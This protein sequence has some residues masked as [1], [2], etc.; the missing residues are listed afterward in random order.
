MKRIFLIIVGLAFLFIS[1]EDD[2]NLA[3]VSEQS[4]ADFY[5][6]TQDF[7]QAINGMYHALASYPTNQFYLSE[8][9][10]D[11]VWSPGGGVRF[12][13]PVNNFERTLA[14][15]S[16]IGDTW[17]SSYRAIF[18]ANI[19]LDKINEEKVP[20][21]SIR[22]RM[23]GEAEFIRALH[24]LDLV[25]FFGRIPIYDKVYSPTE[26]LE[27]GRSS[28]TDVYSLI[29]QDLKDAINKLPANY[30]SSQTGKATS[31][32]AK[33]L[34]AKVYL[35]ESGPDYGI[36]G[37]GISANKYSD[38][39]TLLNEVIASGQYSWVDNYA[40]IFDYDNENNPDIVFDIQFIND[41]NTGRR[42][43]GTDYPMLMY[44]EPYSRKHLGLGGGVPGADG[45]D[46]E[47]SNSLISSYQEG[48]VRANVTYLPEWIDDANRLMK[49]PMFI[50]F[51]SLDHIPADGVNW[52]I[53]I[54]VIRYTDVLLMKAEVLLQTGGSQTEIDAI[55]NQVRSR[56]G[57]DPISNVDMDMLL[58]ERRKEFAAEGL[59]WHDL[60]RTGKVLDVMNAWIDE[61][62]PTNQINKVVANDII[63]PLHQDQLEVKE[64]LYDQNPGY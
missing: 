54:P 27:L 48:D 62:N 46:M 22:N 56:A 55:V 12:W 13:N 44:F 16:L 47:V 60:V 50:K 5:N 1:C 21:N 11:N 10:S 45:G 31:N 25:R 36:N 38:A 61:E 17:N 59:R 7:E 43:I 64:G 52:G 33:A 30:S 8:V 23:I 4:A 14:T 57:V 15:N 53:N 20:D 24:Y 29:E 40:S 26:A 63:Y 34:L 32:A 3:P 9:R 41:G 39:L 6:N 2:L 35:T 37:P 49:V 28:V 19:V 51:L 18:L 58:E 42:G